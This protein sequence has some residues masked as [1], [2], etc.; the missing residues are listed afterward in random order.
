MLSTEDGF[1]AAAGR[2]PGLKWIDARYLNL[3]RGDD[4]S[5][6]RQAKRPPQKP[7]SGA[8]ALFM[9]LGAEVSP[10][11]RQRPETDTRYSVSAARIREPL[12]VEHE[13]ALA[14]L[15][16]SD[17]HLVDDWDS[18]D[19]DAVI[20]DIAKAKKADRQRR[21]RTL[22]ATIAR[23][24]NWTRLYQDRVWAG[25]V[26]FPNTGRPYFTGDGIRATW[27]ARAASVAWMSNQSGRAKAPRD[28][29]LRTDAY[30]ALH[31]EQPDLFAW[32]LDESDSDSPVLEAFAI[33]GRPQVF[34]IVERLEALRDQELAGEEIDPAQVTRCYAAL[35]RYCPGGP[36]DRQSDPLD[37]RRLQGRFR[38]GP[39]L[40]RSK[41]GWRPPREVFRGPDIFD[42]RRPHIA[43]A[44]AER[45]WETVG[46]GIPGV[47]DCAAV[48]GE[49]ARTKPTPPTQGTL[50]AIYQHLADLVTAAR[51]PS[52]KALPPIRLWTDQGWLPS[53]SVYA[54]LDRPLEQALAKEGLPVWRPPRR[55]DAK[56]RSLLVALDVKIVEASAAEPVAPD[57][58]ALVRG[59]E[60]LDYF[61]DAVDHLNDRL[62][63]YD[64]ELHSQ[65]GVDWR[66]LRDAEVAI[67]EDLKQRVALPGRKAAT[68][69]S[70]AYFLLDLL[71]LCV[72]SE[73]ALGTADAAGSA[74]AALF[75]NAE[76][77]D[78]L[79][80]AWESAWSSAINGEQAVG[81]KVAPPEEDS[82]PLGEWQKDPRRPTK[83]GSMQRNS[84]EH[85]AK[86]TRSKATAANKK[87]PK[88]L[89]TLESI[90]S[91]LPDLHYSNRNGS[92][93]AGS[94]GKP[95]KRSSVTLR[96]P[97]QNGGISHTKA[98]IG[99]NE[100]SNEDVQQ[101]GLEVLDDRMWKWFGLDLSDQH[102]FKLV[103]SD[104]V[105]EFAG[106]WVELKAHAGEVPDSETLTPAEA[107]RALD[108]AKRYLLAVV[109]GLEEGATP[110]VRIFADPINTLDPRI[111]RSI[112]VTGIKSNSGLKKLSLP[113]SASNGLGKRKA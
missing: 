36:D 23:R 13:L 96:N 101:R 57:A 79:E 63:E 11:L 84:L 2:T 27:A 55:P 38:R 69:P 67:T 42:G 16:H 74:V 9:A 37:P 20:A 26:N 94:N 78:Y 113:A 31:D 48:L 91:R 92:N 34:T 50:I 47:D 18:P 53:R 98:P 83:R 52:R 30:I 39:G 85:K 105:D 58:A 112:R 25:V 64:Y 65:L 43:T 82:D 61:G 14:R 95:R 35:A 71:T 51:H 56:L 90:L 4:G 15:D 24:S 1:P 66:E 40:V 10:R 102:K 45:L 7:G 60:F 21:A 111:D 75:E 110:D 68:V 107:K 6:A 76:R 41:S 62:V 89:A 81:I 59:S 93:G 77:R 8:R 22:L 32:G 103:G 54:V 104:A 5:P 44:G 17:P 87:Q 73:D 72:Q 108:E 3:L 100:Y 19:L 28:L 97:Q 70:K 12:C 80:L 99:G 106:F 49:L 29:A 46:V 109:S 88:R 86:T 33:E